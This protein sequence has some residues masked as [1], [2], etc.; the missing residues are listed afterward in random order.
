MLNKIVCSLFGHKWHYYSYR[1]SYNTPNANLQSARKCRR[2]HLKELRYL[3]LGHDTMR[4]IPY[5]IE[6]TIGGTNE[7]NSLQ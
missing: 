4:D 1:V 2:C 5:K 7:N 3:T 6:S